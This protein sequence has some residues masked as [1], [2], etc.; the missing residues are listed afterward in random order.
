MDSEPSKTIMEGLSHG[1]GPM[2]D[3]AERGSLLSLSIADESVLHATYMPFIRHGGLFVPTAEHHDLGDEVFLLLGL[4][5][6][7]DPIPV[8]GRVVWVTPPD[9][10]NGRLAGIGVQLSADD[11]LVRS[12]IEQCLGDARGSDRPTHTM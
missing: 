9:A 6:A 2:T 4:P 3:Q 5:G 11:D 1:D 7:R 12:R 10:R 8:A